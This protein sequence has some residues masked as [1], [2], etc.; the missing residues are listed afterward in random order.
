MCTLYG[1]KF[2][3]DQAVLYEKFL[4]DIPEA[5]VEGA[6]SILCRTSVYPPTVAE[7]RRKAEE[8]WRESQGERLP[9]AGRAWQEALDAVSKTGSYGTPHFDDELTEEAVRRFGWKELC[10]QPA[11]T[12][13]V[14]RAQFMK[15]YNTLAERRKK[16]KE[17][18]AVLKGGDLKQLLQSIAD[19]RALQGPKTGN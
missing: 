10:L 17:L 18:Q 15:I 9:D 16:R 13:A 2:T 11:G 1:G 3:P 5:L 8:L 12:I 6:V 14:A 19:K 4:A 7:I